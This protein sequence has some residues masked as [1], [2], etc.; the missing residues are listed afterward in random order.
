M[1]V[2]KKDIMSAIQKKR[3]V[4]IQ[5]AKEKGYTSDETIKHSQELDELIFRYQ[6]ASRQCKNKIMETNESYKKK[7]SMLVW[8]K[9]QFH[10]QPI[11]SEIL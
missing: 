6:V 3:E 5:S 8:P 2:G 4:M 1:Y 10:N 9:Y 7:Q 11:F